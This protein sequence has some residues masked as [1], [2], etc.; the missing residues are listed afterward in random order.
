MPLHVVYGFVA[1]AGV[2]GLCLVSAGFSRRAVA[3]LMF[4]TLAIIAAGGFAFSAMAL[5]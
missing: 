3:A 2:A 1:F 4:A 5:S